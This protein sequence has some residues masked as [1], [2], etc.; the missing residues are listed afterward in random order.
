MKTDKELIQSKILKTVFIFFI[1]SS[2][3]IIFTDKFLEL[4]SPS[5]QLVKT[6]QTVKGIIFVIITSFVLYLLLKSYAKTLVRHIGES[7]EN[8]DKLQ[9]MVENLDNIA[10]VVYHPYEELK[11]YGDTALVTLI[12]PSPQTFALQHKLS[13]YF[14]LI[15]QGETTAHEYEIKG[16]NLSI[17]VLPLETDNLPTSLLLIIINDI[18]DQ[19]RQENDIK[20]A[21]ER[22]E[23]NIKLKNAFIANLS[24]E[25]RTPLNGILGFS[26]IITQATKENHELDKFVKMIKKSSNQLI[27]IIDNLLEV[28]K[29]Q[30]GQ[31]SFHNDFFSLNELFSRI[32]NTYDQMHTIELRVNFGLSTGRDVVIADQKKLEIIVHKLLSNAFKFTHTGFVELGYLILDEKP[33][34]YVQDTGPG[35]PPEKYEAVFESFRQADSSDTRLFGGAGLGLTIAKGLVEVMGGKIWF[36]TTLHVGTTFYFNLPIDFKW[37]RYIQ[38][39]TY[40]V[41]RDMSNSKFLVVEDDLFNFE[42]IK[43]YL[44]RTNAQIIHADNAFAAIDLMTQTQPDLILMDLQLPGMNGL[45]CTQQIKLINPRTPVIIITAF[46]SQ[47]DKENSILAGCDAFLTKPVDQKQLLS[48]IEQ[49]LDRYGANTEAF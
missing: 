28:A 2:C 4:Y 38:A 17:K 15:S 27:D 48:T 49:Q 36:E 10:L 41:T 14:D 32:A 5:I 21:Q 16:R 42:L 20:K 6:I 43:A 8:R 35:I 24:H 1:F 18:T 47:L 39:E 23:E 44:G 34:F 7:K 33:L 25:I 46:A 12:S 30:T 45:E 3:W 11:F 9:T 19:K 37:Q 40:A 29:I 26:E 31:I 22:A 13:E